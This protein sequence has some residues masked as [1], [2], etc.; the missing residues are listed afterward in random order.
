MNLDDIILPSATGALGAFISWIFGKR[1]EDV[2]VKGS[3]LDNTEK[4]VKLWR[5]MAEE[6]KKQVD[7]LSGKVD[8]LMQEVHNLRLENA[9]L[10]QNIDANKRKGNQSNKKV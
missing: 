3:E 5:E 4:A 2:E 7:E 10:R 9:E 1:K 8:T 6:L